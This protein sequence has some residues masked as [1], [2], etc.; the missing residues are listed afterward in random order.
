[1]NSHESN[2]E[3]HARD[4]I[5]SPCTPIYSQSRLDTLCADVSPI[6]SPLSPYGQDRQRSLVTE[7]KDN[8]SSNGENN[9]TLLPSTIRWSLMD[10]DN[11]WSDAA[12][13]DAVLS[14]L[15][16]DPP[17]PPP[18][19]RPRFNTQT[20]QA[21]LTC[22]V[23]F[24][25]LEDGSYPEPPIAAGCDH[26]FLS[27]MHICFTCL[28]QSLDKQLASGAAWLTCPIC[29]EQ[30]SDEEVRRWTSRR[31]FQAYDARR[32][33]QILEED[34]EFVPCVR[35]DC[36]YGQLHPGGLEDPVVVCNSCGTR[37]CFI[38]RD[39]TWHE[40][41]TCAEYD[42]MSRPR[43]EIADIQRHPPKEARGLISRI[44]R[45]RIPWRGTVSTPQY[46]SES[47]YGRIDH[48]EECLPSDCALHEAIKQCPS[49]HTLIERAGGCKFM[50]CMC[51]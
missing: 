44:N 50:Q 23:C 51:L 45:L 35:E 5:V 3:Q 4:F 14:L 22:V 10:D 21:Q 26:A 29:L 27:G 9:S 15:Q 1:M 31:T 6:I 24:G 12:T 34:A 18:C 49:C 2:A 8:S 19:P 37:T 38:H 48:E 46:Q 33:W 47:Q 36:G 32:T 16:K 30:L 42:Q 39:M 25:D 43:A 11:C 17:S 28:S 7:N 41:L 20:S 13:A 40:G